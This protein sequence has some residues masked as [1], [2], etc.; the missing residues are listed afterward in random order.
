MNSHQSHNYPQLLQWISFKITFSWVIA[1]FFILYNKNLYELANTHIGRMYKYQS[2]LSVC[3]PSS[4]EI[5]EIWWQFR[6]FLLMVLSFFSSDE[7]VVVFF[8][9]ITTHCECFLSFVAGWLFDWLMAD[10]LLSEHSQ[11]T[12]PFDNFESF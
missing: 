5:T 1:S 8:L 12:I 11:F 7:S 4:P 10:C 6:M 2:P 3:H 9:I